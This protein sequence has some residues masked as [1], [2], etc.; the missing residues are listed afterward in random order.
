M[1]DGL[2]KVA[3]ERL[4]RLLE[5][6]TTNRITGVLMGAVVTALLQSSSTAS[7]M[8]VGFVNARLMTLSQAVGVI[9]GVNIGTTVTAQLIAFR[10][11]KYA[12]P[13]IAIGAVVSLFS[14]VERRRFLGQVIFGFGLLFLGLEFMTDAVRPL[15]EWQMFRDW[16]ITFGDSPLLG[17][18]AGAV[19]TVVV[20]SSSASIGIL[21]SL[22]AE[23]L[24]PIKSALPILFG[25]NIGT[26]VTATLSAIGASLAA[27]RTAAVHV[28][29]NFIG[30]ILFTLA[31]PLLTPI[32]IAS[33][34]NV[35]RQIA[36]AH[37][38]FNV[39]NT[40]IQLPF[41]GAIVWLV[42]KILP[43]RKEE[44]TPKET[45]FDDRLLQTPSVALGVA[46]NEIMDMAKL[47]RS[48]V[49]E[50]LEGF[51]RDD[52]KPLEEAFRREQQVNAFNR[53][54]TEFLSHLG[55]RRL[56]EDENRSIRE[57]HNVVAN[58]ER[59]GDHGE[60][61]AELTEFSQ[62]DE[63]TYSSSAITDLKEMAACALE[64]FDL[65][66]EAWAEKD[67]AKAKKVFEL[68]RQVDALEEQTRESHIDRLNRSECHP[69][70]GV[71]FLDLASN[72][73]RI[74]DHAANIAA[75]VPGV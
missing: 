52:P 25:D 57:F 31:L 69:S 27:K 67:A 3:G 72:L 36:N 5:V 65:S 60:N 8:V 35:V 16:L 61:I 49:S 66:L 70:S 38:L 74:A 20:Q 30:A 43:G 23:G 15:R 24:V 17:I 46:H 18:L 45:H 58:I 29:F 28:V 54:I 63:L 51:L 7:V 68:E 59:V 34:E 37:T 47:A 41:A 62:R 56:S 48:V 21:Q 13:A 64:A 75:L 6:L 50:S 9:M 32:V 22:A 55:R 2:Q 53:Q 14:K 71:V 26:T 12:L 4:K 33:S 19:M 42:L 11:E 39:A 40:I 10:L 44:P 73:E 1:S